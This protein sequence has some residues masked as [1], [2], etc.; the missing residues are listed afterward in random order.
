MLD[1]W[2]GR[3]YYALRECKRECKEPCK[4]ECKE[5]CEGGEGPESA[6]AAGSAIGYAVCFGGFTEKMPEKMKRSCWSQEDPMLYRVLAR[7]D[8]AG[9]C[10]ALPP[11][12]T[13]VDSPTDWGKIDALKPDRGTHR[14]PTDMYQNVIRGLASKRAWAQAGIQT[15]ADLV[16]ALVR[17]RSDY[18]S[19]INYGRKRPRGLDE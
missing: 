3:P 19:N 14:G 2:N 16:R 7:L 6:I 11:S 10:V 4:R 13:I 9:Q 17:R 5:P 1:R 12:C 18:L 15:Q 8:G